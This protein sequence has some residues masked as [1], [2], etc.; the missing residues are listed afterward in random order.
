MN[1]LIHF[2]PH[3]VTEFACNIFFVHAIA[4]SL[5]LVFF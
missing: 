1:I 2:A 5:S 3:V 4:L